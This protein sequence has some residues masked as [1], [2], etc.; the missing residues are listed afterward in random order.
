[1]SDH[2]VLINN[3]SVF[4]ESSSF[5]CDNVAM[6]TISEGLKNSSDSSEFSIIL[7]SSPGYVEQ[8]WTS[9]KSSFISAST[10]FEDE[11]NKSIILLCILIWN[12]SRDFL[13]TCTDLLSV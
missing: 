5:F 6:K 3:E 7:A 12:C 11:F 4:K 1:M 2:I 9:D 8:D 13:S 10:V